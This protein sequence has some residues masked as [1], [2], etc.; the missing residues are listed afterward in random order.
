MYLYDNAITENLNKLF[1]NSKVTAIVCDS[2]DEA[3]RR[4][5]AE[6]ED[7]ITLPVIVLVGGDWDIEDTSFYSYMNGSDFKRIDEL[8]IDKAVNVISFTPS[9]EMYILAA[10]S[11]ECDMLTREIIFHYYMNPTLTIK[12]PYRIDLIH[13][14][15]IN[16]GK[17][18]RKFQ[19][20][21]GLVYRTIPITLQGAYLWHNNT[22]GIMKQIDTNVDIKLE[23]EIVDVQDNQYK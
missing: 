4:I 3:L 18:I 20:Q 14:F 10:S 13:T 23:S 15:N 17:N 19:R 2:L 8:N 5:A 6:K 1:I 7:K 9:Y 12:I 16:I 22:M 21:S 11:R